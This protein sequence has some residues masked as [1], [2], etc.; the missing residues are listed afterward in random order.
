MDK[1]TVITRYCWSSEEAKKATDALDVLKVE[2][3]IKKEV[4]EKADPFGKNHKCFKWTVEV[5]GDNDEQ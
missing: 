3:A 5:F 2:Y 1:T 4:V